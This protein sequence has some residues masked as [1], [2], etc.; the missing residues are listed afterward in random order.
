MTLAG[1]VRVGTGADLGARATCIPGVR[2][3][4]WSVIGAG[5]V[6]TRDIPN[7]ITAVGVPAR[8]LAMASQYV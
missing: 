2:I 6:V 7:G 5:A 8:D 4:D 3:G 1:S